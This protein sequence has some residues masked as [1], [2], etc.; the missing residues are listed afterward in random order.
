MIQVTSRPAIASFRIIAAV[1]IIAGLLVNLEYDPSVPLLLYFT[2]QSNLMG[3]A[4]L[5]IGAYFALTGRK[6][7][8]CPRLSFVATI[9]LT[10]TF[11]I[12]WTLL[13]PL[14][15]DILWTFFN[16]MEH[17]FAPLLLMIDRL[18]F[19]RGCAP[20]PKGSM[21]ALVYPIYYVIQAMIVGL[22]HLARFGESWFPYPFL[23]VDIFGAWVILNI[24][25]VALGIAGLSYLW[26]WVERRCFKKTVIDALSP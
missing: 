1:L 11:L 10:V 13:A 9:A 22:G 23:D 21:I 4:V 25:L 5:L 18:L 16:L 8:A 20:T 19:Y 17:L 7:A 3:A 15:T 12:F 14:V 6:I 2:V 24:I 26:A